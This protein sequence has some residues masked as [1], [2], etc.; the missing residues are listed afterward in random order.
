MTDSSYES[1]ADFGTLYDAVPAYA[2]RRDVPFYLSEATRAGD[3][4][5]PATVLELGCGTGRVLLP[6]ARSGC[7]VTGIDQSEAMLARCRAK[8]SAEPRAVQDRVTLQEGDV[9]DVIVAPPALGGFALAL[10][11]FRVLQHL[12]TITDQLRFLDAVHHHLSP[13]GRLA[14]DVFNPHYGRMAQ[15]RTAEF[16][17]TAELALDDGRHLRRT[18]RIARVRWVDQV[19]DVELIYHVRSGSSVER[20]VQAFPMRWYTPAELEHLLERAG[21]SIEAMYG[22]FDRSALVDES[23]EIVVVAGRR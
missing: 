20:I 9:R 1:A 6:L 3:G 19:S 22:D 2:G 21:F 7:L 10:A 23:P 4:T 17:D 14:F 8:I 11:P 5:T 15:D 12:T 16:E 13:G 18:A